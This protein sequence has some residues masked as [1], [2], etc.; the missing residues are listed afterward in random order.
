[1]ANYYITCVR[2]DYQNTITHVGIGSD[3]TGADRSLLA[4]SDAVNLI[5]QGHNVFVPVSS[6]LGLMGDTPVHVVSGLFGDFLRT[7]ADGTH[8]DDL[9]YLPSY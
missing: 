4:N 5:R 8:A 7:R 1:M 2:K 9:G 3:R 6:G